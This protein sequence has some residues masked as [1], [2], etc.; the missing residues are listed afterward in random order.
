[1][2]TAHSIIKTAVRNTTK[3]IPDLIDII[4]LFCGVRADDRSFIV[5]DRQYVSMS[6]LY[7]DEVLATFETTIRAPSVFYLSLDIL[8]TPLMASHIPADGTVKSIQ[9]ATRHELDYHDDRL[10]LLESESAPGGRL[11]VTAPDY[12]PQYVPLQLL[13]DDRTWINCN[14][15]NYRYMTM[16]YYGYFKGFT[17]CQYELNIIMRRYIKQDIYGYELVR[18]ADDQLSLV[19]KLSSPSGDV[20]S[21]PV[22]VKPTTD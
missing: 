8:V 2:T 15:G 17:F 21:L 19:V 18:S 6:G 13:V 1:M 12:S 9:V 11:L 10:F 7:A 3:V 14:P 16:Q 4:L 20:I 5:A 22:R